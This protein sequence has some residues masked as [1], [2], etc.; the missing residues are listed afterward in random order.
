MYVVT[1]CQSFAYIP[2]IRF[3]DGTDFMGEIM[4]ESELYSV[5][6]HTLWSPYLN[7]VP[8]PLREA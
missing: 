1:I 7:C 2:A 5:L 8:F 6:T 4:S 3:M